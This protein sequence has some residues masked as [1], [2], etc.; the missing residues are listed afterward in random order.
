V[1]LTNFTAAI[2]AEIIEDDGAETRLRFAITAQRQGETSCFEIPAAQFAGMS[3]VTEQ[4]GA[5]AIVMPGMTLKD[6]AR[7]AIQLL[8]PQ[9]ERRHVYTHLGWRYVGAQ[10][11][12]LHAG[13][14]IG[15]QGSIDEITVAPG[16]ALSGYQLPVPP[17]GNAAQDAIR[18]SLALLEVAPDPVTISV[19]AAL[20]R[21]VLGHVDCSIHLVGPTGQ[22][23]TALAALIQQHWGASMHAR[24]LPASWS[25]TGNALEGIAFA[26]KDAILVVDDFCPVGA[27][28]DIHRYHREADRLLRAQ[29][30]HSGRQRMRADSTLKP[31]KPPRG[32]ILSTG[33]DIPRGQS[34]R[35]RML[36]LEVAPGILRWDVLTACQADAEAGIYAQALAGYLHWLAPRYSEVT[37]GMP[38]ALR[39]LRQQALQEGHR[40][41]PEIVAHVALGMQS[42]LA[43]AHDCGAL[44][45]NECRTYW[46]RTWHALTEVAAVQQEHQAADDPVERFRALLSATFTAGLAHVA[47]ARTRTSPPALPEHWG[48]RSHEQGFGEMATI[49]YQP[50]GACI[51]WC[52]G[53]RLYLDPDVA[54][55]VVQRLAESQQA[56]L[57]M[58]QQTLW[59]RLHERG[60]L[61]R[62]AAQQKNQVR[63]VIGGKTEYVIDIPAYYVEKIGHSGH[64]GHSEEQA[65]QNQSMLDDLFPVWYQQKPVI[66][67]SGKPVM[68]P[69]SPAVEDDDRFSREA[70]TGFQTAI[71]PQNEP[72]TSANAI[73]MTG[74]TRMTGNGEYREPI[75]GEGAWLLSAD[76][77]QQNALPCHSTSIAPGTD[78]PSYS[79]FLNTDTGWPLAQC[80]R[81]DSPVPAISNAEVPPAHGTPPDAMFPSPEPS[82]V[83][84]CPQCRCTNLIVLGA[85][86][87]CPLC[88]W[89]GKISVSGHEEVS[90]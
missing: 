70:M 26:A 83:E 53:D 9:I 14:A 84:A 57:P 87:K 80:A 38:A 24:R 21:A 51:G 27:K 40:R 15:A 34:L 11:V 25:S 55:S 67:L 37:Q 76:D 66:D 77:V 69:I 59:K 85:Y 19:Y 63:R 75:V 7:T 43:Y 5:R 32:L 23:K 56:P 82:P 42:L 78:G 1:L 86:R 41:T 54:F 48:W 13:G 22:G 33:E 16:Q 4:L 60:V 88:G 3:W 65:Q 35:A 73:S 39:A 45:L 81:A 61:R 44:T 18:R 62:E 49:V 52:H 74:M 71:G 36:I 31:G 12:Y 6:H 64:A 30:N 20:W 72:V 58:T 79:R 90:V 2:T 8:S 68:A 46:A 47:D 89:K 10:W 29:G 17:E 50:L 28:A